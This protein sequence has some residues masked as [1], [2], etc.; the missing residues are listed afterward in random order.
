MPSRSTK[1]REHPKQAFTKKE[2]LKEILDFLFAPWGRMDRG[3]YVAIF[4]MIIA[5]AV[6]SGIVV[7]FFLIG[8]LSLKPSLALKIHFVLGGFT[9]WIHLAAM[10]RRNH[11]LG[12]PGFL[13]IV[14]WAPPY[15]SFF[16]LCLHPESL[17]EFIRYAFV[18]GY[19]D[20]AV[21]LAIQSLLISGMHLVH[22]TKEG[23]VGENRYGP[24]PRQESID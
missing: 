23:D 20:F 9:G 1:E 11:D 12:W 2:V 15:L 4:K 18:D 10:I 14:V 16:M 8:M 6:V 19:A 7:N 5:I 22:V 21:Y 3:S 13:P 24:D 17:Y